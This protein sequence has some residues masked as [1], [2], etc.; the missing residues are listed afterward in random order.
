MSDVQPMW[1][2]ISAALLERGWEN[3]T[4]RWADGWRH[5]AKFGGPFTILEAFERQAVAEDNNAHS[6]S[7]PVSGEATR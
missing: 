7:L 3:H 2:I 6:F 5:P 4:T 1:A